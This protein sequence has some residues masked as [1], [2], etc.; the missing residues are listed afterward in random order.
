[1]LLGRVLGLERA[2]RV[3]DEE[4]QAGV[5]VVVG[6][7]GER[8][9][10]AEADAVLVDAVEGVH[11]VVAE[12]GADQV[13]VR[14]PGVVERAAL[15]RVLLVA[16]GAPAGRAG[17]LLEFAEDALGGDG[18]NVLAAHAHLDALLALLRGA[19]EAG[20]VRVRHDDVLEPEVRDAVR[21]D[22][23][24]PRDL[25][26]VAAV[27]AAG[28]V[29]AGVH[30]EEPDGRLLRA[31][32]EELDAAAPDAG[33][34]GHVVVDE[35]LPAAL[36]EPVVLLLAREEVVALAL[37]VVVAER[38]AERDGELLEDLDDRLHRAGEGVAPVGGG[39]HVVARE[40]HEPRLRGGERGAQD[41][42]GALRELPLVLDVGD[43]EEGERAVRVELEAGRRAARGRERRGR[44]DERRCAANEGRGSAA[45]D[46]RGCAANEGRRRCRRM[47]GRFAART[48][49]GCVH[50]GACLVRGSGGCA[51]P[52]HA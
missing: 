10:G 33:E 20:V 23:L 1:M 29:V 38:D 18:L 2:V 45:N 47:T 41:V 17:V 21:R 24:V 22:A 31:G 11:V 42:G 25:V 19:E 35:E 28:G 13:A 46:G 5:A 27:V 14:E 40:D 7:D 36:L 44:K 6:V 51:F 12:V 48:D 49:G 30:R 32:D 52:G 4:A 9:R 50:G 3:D 43:L 16:V 37:R 8:L 39:V 26:G 34:L 15:D